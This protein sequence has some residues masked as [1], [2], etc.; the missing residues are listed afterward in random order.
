VLVKEFRIPLPISLAD[1]KLAQR[2]CTARAS[3]EATTGKDGV[4][5]VETKEFIDEKTGDKGLYT[6]K[7]YHLE[8]YVPAWMRPLLPASA[9][10]LHEKAWDRYP[11]CKTVITNPFLDDKF[12]FEIESMH[13]ADLGEQENILD[14]SD[15]KLLKKREVVIL[16]IAKDQL[17]DKKAIKP[18]E[19]PSKVGN[20]L[21]KP[22]SDGWQ[23]TS[24]PHMCCY[25][26]VTIQIKIWGLQTKSEEYLMN[27]EKD[28]FLS[29]HKKMFCWLDEWYGLSE[30]EIKKLVEEMVQE[31]NKL[32][33]K[34][35]KIPGED[36]EA[37][38][39]EFEKMAKSELNT[40]IGSDSDND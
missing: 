12:S 1:Y 39:K 6:Y 16:D 15:R 28:I 23:K 34:E 37:E 9:L 31:S 40:N 22:L 2:Y 35:E 29:F 11:Y 3:R 27:V 26:L 7:I 8:S 18:E 19:E 25:K 10:Q 14:I 33:V 32:L 24:S 5:L 17:Q 20:K 30:E 13:T 4:E 21:M 36:V 38:K